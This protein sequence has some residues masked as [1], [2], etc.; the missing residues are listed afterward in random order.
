[1][2]QRTGAPNLEELSADLVLYL[3]RLTRAITRQ[4]VGLSN[5]V[6]T[7]SL[8]LLSQI[9]ELEPVTVGALARADRCSQPT[10]SG[11]VAAL[12][13]RGWATKTPHPRDAR[14]SLVALTAEGR[15][16]LTQARRERAAVVVAHLGA[17]TRHDEGDLATTVSV[18]RGLLEQHDTHD[19]E[20][21]R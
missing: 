15:A 13:G 21:S 4:S 3:G 17:D 7:A 18:L 20:G 1:V 2:S 14:S 6:P 9:D 11:G 5:S 12:V 10:M 8:R 19:P 16:V